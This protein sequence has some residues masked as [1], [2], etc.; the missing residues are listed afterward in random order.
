MRRALLHSLFHGGRS[1]PKTE[2]GKARIAAAHFKHGRR[3]PKAGR[4]S[5]QPEIEAR[6]IEEQIYEAEMAKIRAERI[7]VGNQQREEL[8]QRT[9]SATTDLVVVP[10]RPD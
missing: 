8:K 7:V 2:Q 5:R 4:E 9:R 6:K 1:G 3:H 10:Q